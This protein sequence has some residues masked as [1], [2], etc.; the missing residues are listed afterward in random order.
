VVPHASYLTRMDAF[1][2]ASTLLAFAALIQSVGTAMLVRGQRLTTARQ[3][4][5]WCRGLFPALFA[6]VVMYAFVL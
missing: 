3:I 5:L 6:V 1:L 2:L 4:D